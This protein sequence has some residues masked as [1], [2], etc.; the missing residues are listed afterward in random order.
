MSRFQP[1]ASMRPRP[2]ASDSTT[3]TV[4]R[5]AC[6]GCGR[7]LLDVRKNLKKHPA[8]TPGTGEIE[9]T[10][11]PGVHL[12]EH[13]PDDGRPW[14]FTVRC[15]CGRQHDRQE[16]RLTAAWRDAARRDGRVISAVLG[17]DV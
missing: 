1:P 10:A 2:R 14:T 13:F 12:D 16:E 3:A 17:R 7:N 11:R 4:L 9:V 5:L 8:A 15:R 6:D